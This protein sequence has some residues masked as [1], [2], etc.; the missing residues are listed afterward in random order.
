MWASARRLQVV[1]THERSVSQRHTTITAAALTAGGIPAA[2]ATATATATAAITRRVHV[3]RIAASNVR[4]KVVSCGRVPGYQ[5][6]V[7]PRDLIYRQQQAHKYKYIYILRVL[8]FFFWGG[9]GGKRWLPIQEDVG[10]ECTI[11][12]CR[13]LHAYYNA[14]GIV[15]RRTCTTF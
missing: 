7:R 14:G 8:L 9:E 5:R 3:D 1:Y 11:A 4:H 12:A 2:T 15:F 6:I 13:W 10:A